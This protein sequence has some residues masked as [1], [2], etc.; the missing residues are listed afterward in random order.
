MAQPPDNAALPGLH[1][2]ADLY[3]CRCA[4]CWMQDDALIAARLLDLV[5]G[6]GLR[7]VARV[8]HRFPGGGVTGAIVLEE[9]HLALHTWPESCLV[10]MDLYVCNFSGDNRAKARALFAQLLRLYDAADARVHELDRR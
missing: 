1:L 8:F 2:I 9:S 10:T 4:P 6:A 5:A 7:A 3:A